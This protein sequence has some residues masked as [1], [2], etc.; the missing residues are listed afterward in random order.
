VQDRL[1]D[2]EDS[3]TAPVDLN[4]WHHA[5]HGV[6]GDM[7]ARFNT[8]SPQLRIVMQGASALPVEKRDLYLQRI[9]AMLALRGRGHFNDDDVAEVAKLALTG[10]ARQP[11][12]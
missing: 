8:A 3:V 5:I 1:A 6:T 2:W 4:R 10:L 9:A 12:A 7:A 11:A